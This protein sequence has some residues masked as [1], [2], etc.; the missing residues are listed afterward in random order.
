MTEKEE[1]KLTL[2]EIKKGI[3][4]PKNISEDLAYL[5]GILVGD[6]HIRIRLD[7]HD[8]IIKCVGNPKDEKEL[9]HQVIGPCIE[10]VFGFK[11]IIRYQD[12]NTTYGFVFRSKNIVLYLTKIIGLVH[13]KKD[14]NLGIPFAIKQKPELLIPFIRGLFDTDGCI[15]FK[16]RYKLY[17]NYPV[18]SLSSQSKKLI[19]E[20]SFI[21]KSL[22]FKLVETYDYKRDDNRM[23][24]GY[25]II[26]RIEMNGRTN[27]EKWLST[28][29]F[30][31]PKHLEKI[32]K[33]G[34]NNSGERI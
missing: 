19:Q 1:I 16:K 5:S 14:Q 12:Q 20:V 30:Y 21:L 18:I 7:K 24:N 29:N 3:W 2:P 26:N 27:F 11:P 25:T 17:P 13:G 15:C 23:I 32:K 6:G 22:G 10:R 9:Y 34:K 8:Y 33:F 4:I 28:I 31:S